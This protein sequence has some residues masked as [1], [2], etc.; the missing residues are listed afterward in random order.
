MATS[1]QYVGA[2]QNLAN[3]AIEVTELRLSQNAI[4]AFIAFKEGVFAKI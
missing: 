1:T 3:G 2:L 4:S